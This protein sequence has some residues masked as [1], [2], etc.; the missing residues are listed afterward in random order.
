MSRTGTFL[1]II[2]FLTNTGCSTSKIFSKPTPTPKA[3][4]T[5]LP[6]QTFTPTQI[7]TPTIRPPGTPAPG[8]S[9]VYGRVLWRGEPLAGFEMSLDN[10]ESLFHVSVTTD[11][12]GIFVFEGLKNG[13]YVLSGS[14][15]EGELDGVA[16]T[17]EETFDV[18]ANTN[19]NYG[20][21]WLLENDLVLV[22]PVLDG[23]TDETQPIFRWEAYPG[24]AYYVLLLFPVIGN[25]GELNTRT[26]INEYTVQEPLQSCPYKW[27]VTAFDENERPLARSGST[28]FSVVNDEAS[29]CVIKI[30]SP[31]YSAKIPSNRRLSFTWEPNP[32]VARYHLSIIRYGG[33]VGQKAQEIYSGDYIVQEDG[34]IKSP[35]EP[36]H[37]YPGNY[38]WSVK[39]YD[40]NGRL[41]AASP[42]SLYQITLGIP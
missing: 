3:S 41:V 36:P 20:E 22:A 28:G 18:P 38:K 15:G 25:Y 37:A 1:L 2:V 33:G 14:I 29:S 9:N 13:E 26:D 8:T 11:K 24:A 21:Y 6:S 17:Y 7:G 40:E 19:L 12:G 32:L 16:A 34:S 27:D 5:F 35:D 31:E 4:P 30:I 23:E 10:E 39:G 42:T